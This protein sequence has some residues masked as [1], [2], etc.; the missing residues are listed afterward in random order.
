MPRDVANIPMRATTQIP[1]NL[2]VGSSGAVCSD[3]FAGQWD[4]VIVAF[5]ESIGARIITLDQTFAGSMQIGLLCYLRAD[6]TAIHP[7]M[8]A[9]LS[10]I[11]SP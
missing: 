4:Q 9:V 1:N 3:V 6:V 11:T 10:G 8:L 7:E 2:E 5:R